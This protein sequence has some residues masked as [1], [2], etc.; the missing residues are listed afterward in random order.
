MS[1]LFA[2]NLARGEAVYMLNKMHRNPNRELT[3]TNITRTPFIGN[4]FTART[5]TRLVRASGKR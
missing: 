3:M 5:L 2:S 4:N 1:G